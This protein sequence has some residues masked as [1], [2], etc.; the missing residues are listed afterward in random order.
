MVRPVHMPTGNA[1]AKLDGTNG[2]AYPLTIP[3]HNSEDVIKYLNVTRSPR[4]RAANGQ[5]FCN[6][7]AY[8]YC[9]A[10]GAYLPRVWW[11]PDAL[12]RI[13]N[14]EDVKPVYAFSI[15]E[16]NANS[17]Y[18]W[19]V[20]WGSTFGWERVD[21]TTAQQN[22]NMGAVG[23]MCAKR[24][25]ASR[26]GH[27]SVI[28]P[29]SEKHGKASWHEGMVIAPLQCQAGAVNKEYWQGAGWH[30]ASIYSGM[31]AWINVLNAEGVDGPDE[32]LN[33][34]IIAVESGVAGELEQFAVKYPGYSVK[35]VKVMDYGPG[36]GP[37]F[38]VSLT[39]AKR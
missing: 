12:E 30:T 28:V 26:S 8:D 25:D 36:D 34:A 9:Y 21:F 23:V 14:G 1:N 4:Y 27:I 31:G 6:I 17:L 7:F 16:L 5:T 19:L 10:M 37:R 11:K 13:K 22:V 39:V 38:Q 3:V 24:K 35:T 2:R 32:E 29:E 15:V 20:R 33:A 18:D